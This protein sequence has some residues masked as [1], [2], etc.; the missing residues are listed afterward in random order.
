MMSFAEMLLAYRRDAE[1]SQQSFAAALGISNAY[2]SDLERGNRLPSV[3]LVERICEHLGRG[4]LGRR[5]WH[6]AAA[7]AH[8]WEVVLTPSPAPSGWPEGYRAGLE[9]AAQ[10]LN[11]NGQPGYSAE[12]A[13][14]RALPA[15]SSPWR[16]MATAPKDGT[17]VLLNNIGGEAYYSWTGRWARHRNSGR[18][19]WIGRD[20][21]L[22]DGPNMI[23]TPIPPL[24]PAP[25]AEAGE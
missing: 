21:T 2:L 22:L 17:W 14:I 25:P 18:E 24:P 7:K 8:G 23:W 15:P 3:A 9:A 20:G 5:E 16:D 4:P 19:G 11:S 10:W 6:A 12:V 13:A 1:V